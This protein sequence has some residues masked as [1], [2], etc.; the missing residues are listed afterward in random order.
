MAHDT[1]IDDK[2][3]RIEELI[4]RL[5]AGDMSVNDAG[6]LHRE[7]YRHL[8]DARTLL[9]EGDGDVIERDE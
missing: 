9:E 4:D 8:D 6:Q 7:G 1:E 5:E 3:D 2:I